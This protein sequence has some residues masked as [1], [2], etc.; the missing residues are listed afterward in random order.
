MLHPYR[1]VYQAVQSAEAAAVFPMACP[2]TLKILMIQ[3]A[4][5]IRWE[6]PFLDNFKETLRG[7][8]RI[9]LDIKTIHYISNVPEF[10]F[11]DSP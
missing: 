10:S 11:Y 4:A 1:N 6:N 3:M 5:Y 7:I 8:M 2:V 9:F